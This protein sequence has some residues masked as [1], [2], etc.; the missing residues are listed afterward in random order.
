MV[1]VEVEDTHGENSA[2]N[3]GEEEVG[4]EAIVQIRA[5]EVSFANAC[6]VS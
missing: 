1:V 4:E 5:I 3:Q 2:R 6:D